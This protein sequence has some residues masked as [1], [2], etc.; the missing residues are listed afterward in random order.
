[1]AAPLEPPVMIP[2]EK[3]SI[4]GSIK[5]DEVRERLKTSAPPSSSASRARTDTSKF[6]ITSTPPRV[7]SNR[8]S[9]A[10]T[11]S[12]PHKSTAPSLSRND[13]QDEE[14]YYGDSLVSTEIDVKAEF[15]EEDEDDI[16]A[17]WS[18]EEGQV[19]Y[20]S[21]DDDEAS[22]VAS[23]DQFE[24][25][26]S[27][28]YGPRTLVDLQRH[29]EKA[30]AQRSDRKEAWA[31][32]SKQKLS[33][34]PTHSRVGSMR[35]DKDVDNISEDLIK[36]AIKSEKESGPLGFESDPEEVRTKFMN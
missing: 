1:M 19:L 11:P 12:I 15:L 32:A 8:S 35:A 2:V 33:K 26:F 7:E 18:Y 3:S 36:L 4:I 20:D 23:M 24:E 27:S 5:T 31:P 25:F 21:D 34:S 9:P 29:L 28:S 14:S 17:D 6:M 10:A 16:W 22:F 13:S 30:D